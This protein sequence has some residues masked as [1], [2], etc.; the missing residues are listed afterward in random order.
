MRD[1]ASVAQA[2]DLVEQRRGPQVRVLRE[3]RAAVVGERHEA[4]WPGR[5]ALPGGPLAAQVDADGLTVMA[6][7]SAMLGSM[8]RPRIVTRSYGPIKARAA[9]GHPYR[10][11]RPLR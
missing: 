10:P 8:S 4:V 2:E 3:S 7:M 1:T 6:Q 11:R 5:G 9:T